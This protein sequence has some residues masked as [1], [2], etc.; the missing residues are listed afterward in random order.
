V[1]SIQAWSHKRAGGI[2]TCSID[3][4]VRGIQLFSSISI[5]SK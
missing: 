1:L 3:A 5:I 2:E 4:V